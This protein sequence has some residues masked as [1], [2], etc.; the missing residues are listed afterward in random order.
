MYQL[1]WTSQFWT[2]CGRGKV[3][4]LG[5]CSASPRSSSVTSRLPAKGSSF[6]FP[7]RTFCTKKKKNKKHMKTHKKSLSGGE[8]GKYMTGL[9]VSKGRLENIRTEK[10]PP[11]PGGGC[12][13]ATVVFSRKV[14]VNM[15]A[16]F[17]LYRMSRAGELVHDKRRRSVASLGVEVPSLGIL[18][19]HGKAGGTGSLW[20]IP[21]PPCRQLPHR[22][23]T[24]GV[25]LPGSLLGSVEPL[26]SLIL[27]LVSPLSCWTVPRS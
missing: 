17:W 10:D 4:S 1:S 12:Q 2:A 13:K 16:P 20:P 14:R 5:F 26:S 21:W 22:G 8:S 23:Q 19:L 27:K 24:M 25:L 18:W 15:T 9:A 3:R 11:P 6:F 7:T